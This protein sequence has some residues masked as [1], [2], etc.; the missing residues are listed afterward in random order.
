MYTYYNLMDYSF[1]KY[2]CISGLLSN[3]YRILVGSTARRWSTR[4]GR[5]SHDQL[6]GYAYNVLVYVGICHYRNRDDW[7]SGAPKGYLYSNISLP[8]TKCPSA[9]QK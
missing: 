8:G 1:G 2:G 4:E 5:G 7:Q 9:S 3:S 6:D